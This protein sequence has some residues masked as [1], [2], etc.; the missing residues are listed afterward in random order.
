MQGHQVCTLQKHLPPC[1]LPGALECRYP[2]YN[3]LRGCPY[4]QGDNALDGAHFSIM[5]L[6]TQAC[7]ILIFKITFERNI[8]SQTTNYLP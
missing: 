5:K 1:P 2:I 3:F 8:H 7:N 4:Y 6:S